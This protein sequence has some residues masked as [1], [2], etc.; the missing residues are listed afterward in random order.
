MGHE[1]AVTVLDTHALIW[2]LADPAQLSGPARRTLQREAS[3]GRLVASSATV[4]EIATLLR[5]GRLSLATGLDQWLADLS[6]L[7]ELRIEPVSG[8]IARL[9]GSFGEEMQGDPIDRLI[10]ATAL[11]LQ[12]PLV[13]ADTRMHALPCLRAVW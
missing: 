5:R 13:T 7:P 6:A 4:L 3:R 11:Q 9:A 1:P 8:E 2:W 10:V 12:V